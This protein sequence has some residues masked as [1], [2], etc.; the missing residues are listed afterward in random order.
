MSFAHYLI[1]GIGYGL[2]VAF[3]IACLQLSINLSSPDVLLGASIQGIIIGIVLAA[4][5]AA[6]TRLMLKDLP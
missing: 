1:G 3:F 5:T 2:A 4:T 6:V